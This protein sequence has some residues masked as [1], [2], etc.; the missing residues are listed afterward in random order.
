MQRYWT[1]IVLQLFF[2]LDFAKITAPLPRLYKHDPHDVQ[3]PSFPPPTCS[4]AL[5]QGFEISTTIHAIAAFCTYET[6][7]VSVTYQQPITRT[8]T[9]ASPAGDSN[10]IRITL[11]WDNI[12]VCRR[13]QLILSPTHNSGWSCKT[14]LRNILLGCK[15]SC[16]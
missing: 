15:C 8:Y 7:S 12:G 9:S 10:M 11:S 6:G 4:P 13:S 5:N 3:H 14:I 1:I 2:T 16:L